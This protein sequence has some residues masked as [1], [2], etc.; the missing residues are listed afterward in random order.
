[1]RITANALAARQ[2]SIRLLGSGMF[3]FT[4]MSST[5]KSLLCANAME[6][7]VEVTN[8][9]VERVIVSP[10]EE[11]LRVV[12]SNPDA[13]RS[14]RKVAVNGASVPLRKVELKFESTFVMSEGNPLG[15]D[16][17]PPPDPCPRKS[18]VEEPMSC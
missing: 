14:I 6:L 13:V 5:E 2:S 12:I 9:L 10:F 11:S 4:T 1:M 16:P 18:L 8:P 17:N 15:D 7:N 3:V